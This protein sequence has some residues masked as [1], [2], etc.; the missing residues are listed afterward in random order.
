[1]SKLVAHLKG[2]K[3]NGERQTI[4][5]P[6]HVDFVDGLDERIVEIAGSGGSGSSSNTISTI[7][8]QNGTVTYTGVAQQCDWNDYDPLQLEIDGDYEE[9][10]AGTY[11]VGFTPRGNCKWNNGTQDR[12]TATWTIDKAA[13]TL[14]LSADSGSVYVSETGTFIATRPSVW[15]YSRLSAS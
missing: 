15:K 2:P 5:Y 4:N 10:D 11:T 3:E 8:S 1:M 9:T 7:P 6:T 13:G 14:S 12:M